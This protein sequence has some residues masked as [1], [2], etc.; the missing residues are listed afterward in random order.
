MRIWQIPDADS[1]VQLVVV[2]REATHRICTDPAGH[3]MTMLTWF[4]K[5]LL[6]WKFFVTCSSVC[7]SFIC[8]PLWIAK[9]NFELNLLAHF[10][11]FVLLI[12]SEKTFR[13]RN[14]PDVT[15]H[16]HHKWNQQQQPTTWTTTT[17]T[18]EPHQRSTWAQKMW[19]MWNNNRL[20]KVNL[21]ISLKLQT[22]MRE[23]TTAKSFSP[24]QWLLQAGFSK[25][26][27]PCQHVSDVL[28]CLTADHIR[29]SLGSHP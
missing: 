22:T 24:K 28:K 26:L 2:E 14:F 9:W 3:N 7:P 11:D 13:N 8:N 12:T 15:D 19:T 17:R 18:S 25:N 10:C 21:M 5:H 27:K 20:T 16:H 4:L 6:M 23:E 29:W 1:N